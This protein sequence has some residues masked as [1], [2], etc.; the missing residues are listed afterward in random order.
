MAKEYSKAFHNCIDN[1]KSQYYA[2]G[3]AYAVSEYPYLEAFIDRFLLDKHDV[4]TEIAN[5]PMFKD[6]DW[7]AWISDWK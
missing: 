6:V 2:Q 3:Y 4:K 5:A 1:G 7:R